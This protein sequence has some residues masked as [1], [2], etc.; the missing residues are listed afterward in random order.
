MA[1]QGTHAG[2][3]VESSSA[4]TPPFSACSKG[5]VGLGGQAL[6]YLFIIHLHLQ[7]RGEASIVSFYCMAV[8]GSFRVERLVSS[9]VRLVRLGGLQNVLSEDAVSCA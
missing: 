9:P 2:D 6:N 7:V 3:E 4:S 1:S 5:P 8:V